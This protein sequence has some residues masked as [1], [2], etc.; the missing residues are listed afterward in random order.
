MQNYE[1][2]IPLSILAFAVL[3]SLLMDSYENEKNV[4]YKLFSDLYDECKN[5]TNAADYTICYNKINEFQK[6][7]NLNKS[8]H[9]FYAIA[10]RKILFQ[11]SD[12]VFK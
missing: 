10:L 12:V 1:L 2:L 5:I 3:S 9:C 6:L 7:L 4:I 8:K 11:K